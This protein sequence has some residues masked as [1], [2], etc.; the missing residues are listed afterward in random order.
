MRG[1]RN[2]Q[3]FLQL[4][5]TINNF[6]SNYCF[7]YYHERKFKKISSK[8]LKV[9]NKKNEESKDNNRREKK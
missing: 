6:Y 3:I 2:L 8:N 1:R 5:T 9:P 7:P 4:V